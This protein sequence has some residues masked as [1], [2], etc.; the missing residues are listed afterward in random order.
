MTPQL[1]Q[2]LNAHRD[3]RANELFDLAA[4]LETHRFTVDAGPVRDAANQC[5]GSFRVARGDVPDAGRKYWGYEISELR[6]QLA[7]QRHCRPRAAKM[8]GVSGSLTVTVQEY[9]PDTEAQIGESFTLLRRLDTD[10]MFD[11]ELMVDGEPHVVRAAW[12]LDTHLH[13]EVRS[14]AAH[15]RFHFQVGGE[16][17][18]DLD[19]AI[20][21]VFVPEAPRLPCAPLDGVL[22]VDFVLSHYCGLDWAALRDLDAG[23]NFLRK[24]PMQR[25]WQ[26]YYRTISDGLAALD[27]V[28]HGGE[29]NLLVP[30]IFI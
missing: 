18:D 16:R 20:R 8:E 7:A 9:V 15:P 19:H 25:Y 4:H 14:H 27:E 13:T 30:S 3:E 11:A 5:R 28:P 12:H 26:P 23:Y 24:R 1:L 6:I 10:F 29:A 22:A 21:G 17:L 2:R